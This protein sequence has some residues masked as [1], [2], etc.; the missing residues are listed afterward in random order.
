MNN[1]VTSLINTL[2]MGDVKTMG[3]LTIVPLMTVEKAP[4]GFITLRRALQKGLAEITE[5]SESGV[6]GKLLVKNKCE[7]PLLIV[8]G[9]ELS[10]AKQNRIVNVTVLLEPM[11][12]TEVPVSCTERG[13][14]NYNS[15]KFDDSGNI[16]EHRLR[17]DKSAD[18]VDR[19]MRMERNDFEA[20]QM[21][22]WSSIEEMNCSMAPGERSRT[23]SMKDVFH[24]QRHTLEE[25]ATFFKMTYGQKGLLSI[26]NGKASSIDL[27][28]DTEAFADIYDK[29]I[30]SLALSVAYSQPTETKLDADDFKIEAHSFL[31]K[32][33][34]CDSVNSPSVSMGIDV[35]YSSPALTGS[36]L[37]AKDF[38]LHIN[39]FA[40]K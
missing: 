13:R 10:G 30:R 2:S 32:I 23:E 1:A 21:K 8:D 4:F 27:V 40:R 34:A 15:D 28:A 11:Q 29:L 14:W 33:G 16:A 26:I 35:C 38:A 36:A 18:L 20:D 5:V 31:S 3:G 12:V 19:S 17:A 6:V 22:V 24:S 7:L 9:E 39:A 37:V 25:Y